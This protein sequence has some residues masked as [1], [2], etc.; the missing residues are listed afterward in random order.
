MPGERVQRKK[1]CRNTKWIV[2]FRKQEK[3][4]LYIAV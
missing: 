4:F 1:I 3:D 2:H